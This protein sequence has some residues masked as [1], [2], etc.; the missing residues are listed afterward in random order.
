MAQSTADASGAVFDSK[1][2]GS[3]VALWGSSANYQNIVSNNNEFFGL[4]AQIGSQ[5]HGQ[6]A[7]ANNNYNGFYSDNLSSIH[8][9]FSTS[10]NSEHYGYRA[11]HLS[12]I[13]ATDSTTAG[14]LAGDF[15][16]PTT[17]DLAD[18]ALMHH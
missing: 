5:I 17:L 3:A 8:A 16:T 13:I 2:H 6:G 12:Y 11:S 1:G 14:N 7:S 10:T 4:Q 15:S 9:H 18:G